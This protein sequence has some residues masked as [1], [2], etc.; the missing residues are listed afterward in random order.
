MLNRE[1]EYVAAIAQEGTLSG[2]AVRLGV[3]QP[4]LSRFLKKEE[5]EL[6]TALFQRIDNR[7]VLT[8]AGEC[9]LDYVEQIHALQKRMLTTIADIAK[10]DL[11]RLRVGITGIRRPFTIFSVIPQFKK[12]YPS[13]DLTLSECASDDL[14][15][16]LAELELDCI[17]VNVTKQ[18]EEFEYIPIAQEEY[19]LAVYKDDP[20]VEKARRVKGFRYPAVRPEDL[21]DASFIMLSRHH[22]IRQFAD[23][24]LEGHRISYHLAMTS[25]TLDSALE[26]VSNNLGATFTPEVQLAY[27]RGSKNIRYLSINTPG[28]GYQF[29]LVYR[30]GAY[31][32]PCARDFMEMFRR[33]FHEQDAEARF[34]E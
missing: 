23:S 34:Y 17:A 30:K 5:T 18:R 7:M 4:A 10:S 22:R 32:Q 12:K 28:V 29:C 13:V 6:G 2:A 21:A 31:L 19:V 24:V 9:Y 14:E 27:I 16:M 11:G 26:A 8:Y 33:A 1:Y 15:R 20:L 25:R 3:S